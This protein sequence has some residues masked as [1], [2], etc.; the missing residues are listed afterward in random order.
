[1]CNRLLKITLLML[2]TSCGTASD[3]QAQDFE[4]LVEAGDID[5]NHTIVTFTLPQA[6]VQADYALTDEQGVKV[7][8][9]IDP[10]N[11]AWFVLDQLEAGASKRYT[12]SLEETLP[13]NTENGVYT[14][15]DGN[16]IHILNG[17][18]KVASYYSGFNT[19]PEELEGIYR[20]GGY[21]HPIYTPDGTAV[22][23]HLNVGMHPHHSGIWSAWTRTRYGN[24]SPDF[25]N[26]HQGTGRVDIESGSASVFPGNAVGG[27]QSVHNFIQLDE[28]GT[29]EIVLRERWLFQAYPGTEAYHVF[30]LS[31]L[32]MMAGN[33]SLILPEYHYGGV[34]F[35]G[36]KQWDNPENVVI[37]TSG[38]EGRAENQARVN[39]V[40]IGGEIDGKMAGVQIMSDPENYGHPQPVRI[41]PE[42]PFINFAPQQLGEMRIDPKTPYI[43]R[44]R[45][46]TTD[47]EPDREIMEQLWRDF[48]HPVSVIVTNK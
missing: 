15:R 20:R 26:V 29:Q 34:G 24:H 48:A 5:R 17:R 35:R 28:D 10:D 44:Y 19:P 40:Y 14:E 37:I 1:M 2:I 46:I 27:F 39:W 18:G 43:A 23:N 11:V 9:T 22:T 12:L 41:H 32:Q 42:E 4:I 25:W 7:S 30:D 8:L 6:A 3:P 16:Q 36:H 31:V 13:F 38:G 47:G 33:R 21:L 45:F